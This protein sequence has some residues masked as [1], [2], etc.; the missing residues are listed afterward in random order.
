MFEHVFQLLSVR[1]LVRATERKAQMAHHLP[2]RNDDHKSVDIH[3][4]LS[5]QTV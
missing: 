5:L 1:S 3:G 4:V 2:P